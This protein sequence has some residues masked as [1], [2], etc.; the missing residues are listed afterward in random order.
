MTFDDAVAK[1]EAAGL[2][3]AVEGGNGGP[4]RAVVQPDDGYVG[5][6]LGMKDASSGATPTEAL[7][8]ALA[9]YG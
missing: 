3:W 9:T 4:Y 5:D 6:A 7:L 1:V 2:F 8:S